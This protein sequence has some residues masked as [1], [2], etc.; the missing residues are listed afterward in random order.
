MKTLCPTCAFLV[1]AFLTRAS[2]K[3][4]PPEFLGN[5][6]IS[7]HPCRMMPTILFIQPN[8]PSA[9]GFGCFGLVQFISVRSQKRSLSSGKKPSHTPAALP[10]SH[11]LRRWRRGRTALSATGC[12][13]SDRIGSVEF[14]APPTPQPSPV[15]S[16]RWPGR[17]DFPSKAWDL[18][19]QGDI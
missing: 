6:V 3:V 11:H 7:S 4:Y 8:D 17:L 9:H 2:P 12:A 10:T 1:L 5:T 14:V 16:P 18:R 13:S 15:S 19:A